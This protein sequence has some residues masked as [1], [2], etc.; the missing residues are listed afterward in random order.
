M[1][2]HRGG[3]P[4]INKNRLTPKQLMN[5]VRIETCPRLPAHTGSTVALVDSD[6]ALRYGPGL[7]HAPH[8]SLPDDCPA[9]GVEPV[10]ST[11]HDPYPADV[12]E[13]C[14]RKWK[15]DDTC[16]D[17][18]SGSRQT[19]SRPAGSVAFKEAG[20]TNPEIFRVGGNQ[21]DHPPLNCRQFWKMARGRT[22]HVAPKCVGL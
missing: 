8:H 3:R 13:D 16:S 7:L 10:V 15:D 21:L 17:A 5:V 6:V 19:Q 9:T 11:A 18:W 20:S 2:I 4:P 12:D 1:N 14:N 22:R